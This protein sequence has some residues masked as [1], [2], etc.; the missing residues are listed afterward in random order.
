MRRRR[1]LSAPTPCYIGTAALIALNCNNPIYVEDYEKDRRGAVCL[2]SLPHRLCPVGI[3]TQDQELMER[4]PIP[5]A[6]ERVANF[7][8]ATTLEVQMLARACGKSNIH[9]LEP[10]DMRALTLEAAAITGI[11][12]VGTNW[13]PGSGA[14]LLRCPARPP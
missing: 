12:L 5:E 8:H 3:T 14:A 2:P 11:P 10:E 4:L 7:L 9:D 6:A 1:S 13:V